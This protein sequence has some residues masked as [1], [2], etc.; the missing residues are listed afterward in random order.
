MGSRSFI[1]LLLPVL[2]ACSP[3]GDPGPSPTGGT[4]GGGGVTCPPNQNYNGATP[5]ASLKNDL[6]ADVSAQKPFGGIFRRACAASSCHDEQRPEAGLFVSPPAKDPMTDMPI[7][8]T[9]EQ[10]TRFLGATD[11]VL[12][13]SQTVPTMPIVDPGKPWNSFLMR[14]LDGCFTDIAGQCTPIGTAPPP[15]GTGM[16]SPGDPLLPPDERDIVRRWI[17]QG[18]KDI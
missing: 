14:K 5:A 1:A 18:A 17:F 15:C 4:G 12:R 13:M 7:P 16:P 10:V 8:I 9:P 11:G 3:T 6:L 2:V